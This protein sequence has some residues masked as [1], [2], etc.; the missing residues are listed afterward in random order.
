MK[1]WTFPAEKGIHQGLFFS[2]RARQAGEADRLR[3]SFIEFIGI[4][5]HFGM[6]QGRA[7]E[8]DEVT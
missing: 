8:T 2:L 6:G 3:I 5:T 1:G 7:R 4:S